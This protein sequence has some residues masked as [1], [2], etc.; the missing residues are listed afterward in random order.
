MPAVCAGLLPSRRILAL[1]YSSK[2]LVEIT[3]GK[4]AVLALL[5]SGSS[6]SLVNEQYF[7]DVLAPS[8]PKVVSCQVQC[9]AVN[10]QSFNVV[11]K[12]MC[13]V[14]FPK[15]TW[16]HECYL[17][18]DLPHL[19]ILGADF[20]S[21]ARL[22]L[23]FASKRVSFGFAPGHYVPFQ[24]KLREKTPP[25][26]L[27][28]VT[29][30][31][32]RGKVPSLS[33]L[34]Q[35][36]ASAVE[37]LVQEFS[38]LFSD[39]LGVTHLSTYHIQLTDTSPVKLPPYRL[40]PPKMA[41][42]KTKIEDMVEKGI[43]RPSTSTYSSPVFLVPKGEQDFRPVVD[44]RQLNKR[45]HIESTPM[46]DLHTAAH[47]FSGARIFTTLDLNSAYHQIPLSEECK[48]VTAFSTPW[49]L[50][51]FNR[52]PFGIATGAQVLSRLLDNLF[53]DI[54]FKYLYHYLDDLV[55]YSPDF[56]SHLVH[57]REVFGRLQQ[58][59]LTVRRSKVHFATA[60]ISFLGHWVS[61][62]GI[63]IDLERTKAVRNFPPPKNLR[64]L[65][66]FIGM[67]NFFSKFIPSF[68]ARVE[69]LNRL[70]RKGVKYKWG[71]EQQAAFDDLKSA[72]TSPPVLA[73][74]D[75]NKTFVLQ[76][77]AST[78][79]LAAV[80]LQDFPEGRRP[81]YYS[82]RT[83]SEAERKFSIYELET[84]AV[85]FG[86]EKYKAYLEH[87][88]FILECDNQALTWALGTP[89][90]TGRLARW[91]VRI[92]AF[93][94][95]PRH[96]RGSDNVV[97]DALTRMFAEEPSPTS[98]VATVP[99]FN[100]CM[101]F[102]EMFTSIAEHQRRDAHLEPIIRQLEDD[103]PVPPYHVRNGVL[104]LRANVDGKFK[105]VVPESVI[106]MVFA[107]FHLSSFGGHLG[108]AKTRGKIRERFIWKGMDRDIATRV[109]ACSICSMAKPAQRTTWGSLASEVAVKPLEKLFVDFI[110]PFPR[111][112][113]GNTFAL[114]V[115]DAFSKFVWLS[116]VPRATAQAVT[117]VMG[118]IFATFG[119]PRCVVSDNGSQFTSNWFKRFC[120]DWG[121][122]HI[123]TTPY[124][125]K[126]S[127]AERVNRNLKSALIAYHHE[128]HN[129]WDT[130]LGKL[131]FA[132]NSARHEAHQT[133]PFKLLFAFVPNSPLANMWSLN[134]LLPEKF[135]P[136]IIRQNW[137]RAFNNLK[138]AHQLSKRRYDEDRRPSP[139]AVGQRVMCRAF[140]VSSRKDAFTAKLAPRFSGPYEIV[141]IFK[142]V[143]VRLRHLQNGEI[144]RAHITQLKPCADVQI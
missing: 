6:F 131:Q 48:H 136:A 14:R 2:P 56:D 137:K 70:R 28:D 81:V 42:L 84:L 87:V 107:Y 129:R 118:K 139:Y 85:L 45:L 133:T 71:D 66:R 44:Y 127:H 108:I 67:A 7:R 141:S 39:R 82:S 124:Y 99:D 22:V 34:S 13:T 59:G 11:R 37:R 92:G 122:R 110:G 115:V 103:Q 72:I 113:Q 3:I 106:P 80:L 9:L 123:T 125:P 102:P 114:V 135:S 101:S 10:G 89:R 62:A 91:G 112:A 8:C 57:L 63:T 15:F 100:G 105:I 19:V 117:R 60:Q 24:C 46:P 68:A 98:F 12:V 88:P 74:P 20:M 78:H 132:F 130:N 16:K 142:G 52:V 1:P 86:L 50:Y 55:I 26:R 143:S 126:P 43:I 97:A 18:P 119:A 47:H 53:S 79:S 64:A 75:F 25:L 73:F 40:T 77:D 61:P 41:I 5:D 94:F 36:H 38:A 69:P 30:L 104:M 90:K 134:D 21:R 29:L 49:R 121:T 76:T 140:P 95:T 35:E 31:E 32:E 23:D 116:G 4:L 111:S 27:S 128:H 33:H 96:I 144:R 83:L 93:K 17:V 120:F 109:K 138:R 51:E 54:K 65:A 58:A